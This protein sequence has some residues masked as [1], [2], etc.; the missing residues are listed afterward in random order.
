MST[1]TTSTR[2]AGTLYELRSDTGHTVL[3]E[4]PTWRRHQRIPS[5][6][7]A[8]VREVWL[9]SLAGATSATVAELIPLKFYAG[10]PHTM[11]RTAQSI[12]IGSIEK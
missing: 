5:V 2:T 8:W 9:P 7:A 3:V 11:N 4:A 6:V 1:S 10:A 12:E